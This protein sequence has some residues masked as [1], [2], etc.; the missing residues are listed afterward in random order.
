M[1]LS[2]DQITAIHDAISSVSADVIAIRLFGSRLND[3][4][5]GGD[6]DL[7]VD[8]ENAIEQPALLSARLAT[9]VSR[10]VDNRNVDVVLRAPNL[11]ET[12]IHKIALAEGV[13]LNR[14]INS[15]CPEPVEWAPNQASQSRP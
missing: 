4:A 3:A 2:P 6:I 1:R 14:P 9:R 11:A 10:A 13:L 8:F 7:M 15:V 5:R 12:S